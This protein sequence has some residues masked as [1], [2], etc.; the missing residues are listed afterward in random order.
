MFCNSPVISPQ[1]KAP[2]L[3]NRGSQTISSPL[4]FAEELYFFRIIFQKKKDFQ[5]DLQYKNN[6]VLKKINI[7]TCMK[8]TGETF[9]HNKRKG[10]EE[11]RCYKHS[12]FQAKGLLRD[13]TLESFM[14]KSTKKAISNLWE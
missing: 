13:R 3:S 4:V 9:F 8:V 1:K 12:N 7:V 11:A 10:A 14:I 6:D 5:I 2:N